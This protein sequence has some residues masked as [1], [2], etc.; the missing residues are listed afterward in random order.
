MKDSPIESSADSDSR[1]GVAIIGLAGR[2]PGAG[3]PEQFWRNLCA[4]VESIRHFTERELDDW[5]SEQTRRA[6]NYVKAR[7]VLDNI[8]MFDADFFGMQAREAE[9]TDPQHRLFLEC[10]WEALEDGGYDPARYQGSIG[11]FAG[12]SLNTYFLNNVCRD[13]A[14]IERFTSSYQVDCYPELIGAGQ[15]FLATRVAYKLDLKGPAL[16]LQTACSTSLLAVVQ[17][18]Q[19]LLFYQSDMALAGGVSISLPQ[20]RGYLHQEGGMVSAD[21]T[22]RP[23]DAQASGT[24]FG[25][26][27]GCVLLKRLADALTDGDHIYAVLRGWGVNNDGSAKVGFT[28]PSADGQAGAIE[29]AHAMAGIEARSIS[30]VEC[31][32]TAAAKQ[33][34]IA[35]LTKAFGTADR[36]FCAIGSV[37]GNIGHLDAAAGIAGLMKTVLAL[38]HR[39]L[40]ASLHYRQTNPQIDFTATPIYVIAESAEWRPGAGPLRAGVSAFGI[41]GT[42]VHV[43][44]EEAPSVPRP[45]A[46]ADRAQLMVLSA[47]SE[48]ALEQVCGNLAE[49]IGQHPE[50]RLADIAHTLQVGRRDFSY[51]AALLC[52]DSDEAV[53]AL[54]ACKIRTA[55]ARRKDPPVVFMFPGQ[56]TQYPEMGRGLYDQEAEFHHHFDTC[57]ELL[58]PLLHADLRDV[59]YPRGDDCDKGAA[60]REILATAIAQPAIFAVEYATARLWID[61]GVQ[62]AAMVG[63][64]IGEFV[65]ATLAGVM[66]L[67]DALTVVAERGRLMGK[68]PGGAML[69]VRLPA[70]DIQALI[71]PPLAIAAV[72]SP[73]L[74]VVAGPHGAIDE[75]AE[76]LG[77]RG[78]MARRLHTSHAFHSPMMDPIVEPLAEYLRGVT[79][80]PPRLPYVSA[81]TGDWADDAQVTSADYW[82]RQAREPVQFAAAMASLPAEHWP[83]LLEVGP[84]NALAALARAW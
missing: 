46:K 61:W 67:S 63:H 39:R 24:I 10:A 84:G 81:V 35:G 38:R 83:V 59:L 2:F 45:A 71:A 27:A 72:N 54:A 20:N 79:L 74:C 28:A 5:F 37:K 15:D 9:L 47:R 29:M 23:F 14:A 31:H 16:T 49:H 34:E 55:R 80:S 19:N 4:G 18:A 42:N 68:L 75:L 48:S 62:P 70:G 58:K 69:A 50:Q 78:V 43:V 44:L 82:A 12:S 57:A 76:Q 17:A 8:E 1:P 40:P 6:P 13:R 53:A 77:H 66:S 26:G 32:G 25:S 3:T 11:V 73:A 64:S 52:R 7:P 36:Q 21:G 65:A 30:Y 22:C 60:E 33:I 41:G 56:G 51:R